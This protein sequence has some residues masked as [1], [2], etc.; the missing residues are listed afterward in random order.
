MT[1]PKTIA[2]SEPIEAHGETLNELTFRPP[3]GKDFRDA[4]RS[5]LPDGSFDSMWD[6]RLMASCCGVPPSTIDAMPLRDVYKLQLAMVGFLGD[7]SPES[8]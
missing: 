2:L 6:F 1:E 8:S 3:T 4:G 7:T 5:R